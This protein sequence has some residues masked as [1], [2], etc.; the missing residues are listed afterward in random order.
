MPIKIPDNSPAERILQDEGVEL[1]RTNLALRQDIRPMRVLLLNLMPSKIST[2]V[3]LARLLSHTPLQVELTLLTTASYAPKHTKPKHLQQFY[4][5]HKDIEDQ[6]FDSLVIT[7]SPVEQL[8]FDQVAYWDELREILDWSRTNVFRRLHLCWAAQAGLYL[9]HG[10][11]KRVLSEK[12]FGVFPQKVLATRDLLM[13]GFP[14]QFWCPVSRYAD[15]APE[16]I[17]ANPNLDMLAESEESGVCA[18]AD[19]NGRDVYM[20]NHLEYDTETL[21]GEY[22][23]DRDA[24]LAT[25]IPRNYF[26]NDDPSQPPI[27]SWRPYAYLFFSNWMYK[28]YEDTPFDLQKL[29][30]VPALAA[31]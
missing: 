25:G 6:F 14:D 28:L 17:H 26:P 13:R 24:G 29:D 20:L 23:R 15:V 19:R 27:N 4:H 7:G 8:P 11:E 3:Q 5:V 10:I 21:R 18:V 30:F 22:Y 31:K 1:I 12:V 9:Q 16:D 2:E